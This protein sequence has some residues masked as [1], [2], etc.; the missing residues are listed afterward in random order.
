MN[1]GFLSVLA[2]L[3]LLA[4]GA[5]YVSSYVSQKPM[6]DA[7]DVAVRDFVIAF[8]KTI[9]MVPLYGAERGTAMGLY[10][11]PFVAPELIAQWSP[12]GAEGALGRYSSSPAPDSIDIV[13]VQK[14]A[15]GTFVVEANVIEVTS[16]AVGSTTDTQVAAVY[17]VTLTLKET[18]RY[19]YRITAVT[20]G[21]YSEIPRRQTVVGYWECV[22][23]KAGAPQTEECVR[24]I[25]LEQSDGHMIVDTSLMSSSVQDFDPGTKLRI[26]GV[27][28]PSN[29]LNTDRWQSYDIDAIIGA[30][31]IEALD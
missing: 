10:Y 6:T 26:S 17:P 7:E 16:E 12:E 24:G 28:M 25:A 23:K 8:G 2:V 11:A 19:Q 3:V 18:D 15:P 1:K 5:W 22:P 30:T 29:Q 4:A 31:V 14:T 20:K 27:V 9:K 21:A 13:T